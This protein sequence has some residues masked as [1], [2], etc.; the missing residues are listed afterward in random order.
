MS[1]LQPAWRSAR[2]QQ[3]RVMRLLPR[4]RESGDVLPCIHAQAD[5][6]LE[7]AAGKAGCGR[8]PRERTV[9]LAQWVF[10]EHGPTSTSAAQR[11]RSASARAAPP[12][13]RVRAVARLRVRTRKRRLLVGGRCWHVGARPCTEGEGRISLVPFQMDLA[14]RQVAAIYAVIRP[15]SCWYFKQQPQPSSPRVTTLLGCASSGRDEQ[16]GLRVSYV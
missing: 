4:E 1:R 3:G 13:E 12:P 6:S 8:A 7:A 10:I 16:R 14:D 11:A 2:L 9:S 15:R 5:C